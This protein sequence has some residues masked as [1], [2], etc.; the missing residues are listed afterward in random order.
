MAF[1]PAIPDNNVFVTVVP[2]HLEHAEAA[3]FKD[4]HPVAFDRY[5]AV[6]GFGPSTEQLF[7]IFLPHDH[8]IQG[9]AG[10]EVAYGHSV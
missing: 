2:G 1:V 8:E 3:L 9:L 6:A 5:L 7:S 4:F 10:P